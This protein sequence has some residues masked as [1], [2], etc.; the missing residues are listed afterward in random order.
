MKCSAA[1]INGE[2]V[3]V[4]KDPITDSGKASLKGRVTLWTNSGGEFATSVEAPTGWTDRGNGQWTEALVEV[5][6]DGRLI[7]DYT[8]DEV[9]ANSMK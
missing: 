8:F 9:R 5:Y 6:R 2:W 3:D 1:E 7:R 4:F